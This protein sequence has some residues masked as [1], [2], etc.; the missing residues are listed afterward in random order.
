MTDQEPIAA[1]ILAELNAA[2]P[3]GVDAYDIDGVPGTADNGWADRPATLV[4]IRLYRRY[5]DTR[6]FGGDYTLPGFF[7][8]TAYRGQY[9]QHCRE[10]R[11][12]VSA[13]LE[14][15]FVGTYGPFVFNDETQPIDDDAD[16]G[17]SGTDTWI[18]C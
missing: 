2:L 18:F 8:D 9:V 14:N 4:T 15:Q 16:F 12:V 13:T 6:R 3:T 1:A 10:L 17:F 7:L 5:T 11:R